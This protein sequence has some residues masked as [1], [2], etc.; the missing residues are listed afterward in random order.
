MFYE[1]L[2]FPSNSGVKENY[3]KSQKNI[4]NKNLILNDF[5][6]VSELLP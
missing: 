4:Q 2:I 5:R 6:K 3:R 1:N